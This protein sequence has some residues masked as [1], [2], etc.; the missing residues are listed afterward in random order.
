MLT[1][2]R[3]AVWSRIWPIA[4]IGRQAKL[5]ADLGHFV[6]LRRQGVQHLVG[7]TADGGRH[8]VAEVADEL[9]EQQADFD[10]ALDRGVELGQRGGRVAGHQVAAR[11]R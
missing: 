7:R 1:R 5:P 9:I 6:G 4:R 11:G 10:A 8:H 3:A 2:I